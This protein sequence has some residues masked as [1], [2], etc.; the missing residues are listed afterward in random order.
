MYAVISLSPWYRQSTRQT[1]R[2]VQRWRGVR[3][4]PISVVLSAAGPESVPF[5]EVAM[6]P[7][8]LY[9][10]GFRAFGHPTWW[11]FEP[12]GEQ[13]PLPGATRRIIGGSSNYTNLGL[14]GLDRHVIE[15][16]RFMAEMRDFAGKLD[17]RGK[18]NAIL[19][20][21]LAAE[22]LRFDSI[23]QLCYE[24]INQTER[25]F[26]APD[27]HQ[28]NPGGM[29]NHAIVFTPAAKATVR[30]WRTLTAAGDA[31]VQVPWIA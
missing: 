20:C 18:A 11:E 12:E 8:S 4:R 17:E 16:W 30:S 9:V 19:L 24:W 14:A 26:Q 15:P 2:A 6:D 1:R 7:R 27:F 13:P 23:Q 29:T 10:L 25:Y 21:F 22:S 3:D 31:D 28:R 5:L